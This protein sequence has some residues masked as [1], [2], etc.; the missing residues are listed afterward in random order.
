MKPSSNFFH[1]I[2]HVLW[3]AAVAINSSFAIA[4]D[5]KPSDGEDGFVALFDG[6]SFRGWEGNLKW[7]RIENGAIIA[8]SL[9]EPIP[10]NEFL[11]T[12]GEFENFELRLEVKLQGQ[13]DNAGV[14]FRS[15]RVPT[16]TE[17][18]GYQADI[19]N[20][21][22]R[23]VWAGIYDESRRNKMLIEGDKEV[24]KSALKPGDWN[25]LRVRAEGKHITTW[26]NGQMIVKYEE[27]DDGI[28]SRGIIAL[29][30]HSGP[31]TEALYRNIR[32]KELK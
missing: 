27:K 2:R 4:Q 7:F 30:I 21:W 29:Q 23:P 16:S 20:A 19:G 25:E 3:I 26:L 10:H 5:A 14:Q 31:P 11:A 18:S 22:E 17:V 8:G 28:A 15:S 12:T 1:V 32:I 24:L 13:G 9:K 6:K